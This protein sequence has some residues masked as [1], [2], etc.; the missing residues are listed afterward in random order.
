MQCSVCGAEAENL[1]PGNFDG[2]VVRCKHCGDYQLS[3][4]VL[5]EFLRL[6]FDARVAALDKARGS[7]AGGG[8]PAIT[9]GCLPGTTAR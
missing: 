7:A 4:T 5:N 1:T 9:G 6:D 3:D 2:L 8:R